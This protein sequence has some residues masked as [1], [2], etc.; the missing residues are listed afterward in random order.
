MRPKSPPEFAKHEYNAL[1][2]QWLPSIYVFTPEQSD[3]AMFRH[4][5]PGCSSHRMQGPLKHLVW[6]L[7]A[8]EHFVLAIDLHK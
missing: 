8:L 5:Y 4:G 7:C 2:W 1:L 6:G 3:Y